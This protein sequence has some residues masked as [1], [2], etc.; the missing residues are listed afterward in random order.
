ML[1]LII[2]GAIL[3]CCYGVFLEP[4]LG[5]NLEGPLGTRIRRISCAMGRHERSRRKVRK[6][7]G[8]YSSYCKYC[9]VVLTR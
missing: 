5:K 9:G 3:L 1:K 7:E 4:A 2:A 8:G 6:V